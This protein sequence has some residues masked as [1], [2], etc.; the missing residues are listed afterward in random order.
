MPEKESEE[1]IR[2]LRSKQRELERIKVLEST[3]TD[4]TSNLN[5]ELE[6]FEVDKNTKN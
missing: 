3:P 4:D 5:L 1:K 2:D 6:R